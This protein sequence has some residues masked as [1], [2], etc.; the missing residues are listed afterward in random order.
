M[1]ALI[2]HEYILRSLRRHGLPL[3]ATAHIPALQIHPADRW[4]LPPVLLQD[5]ADRL[6]QLVDALEQNE[7]R[8]DVQVGDV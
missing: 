7:P 4:N 5:M 8:A 1:V 6:H 2:N 3:R